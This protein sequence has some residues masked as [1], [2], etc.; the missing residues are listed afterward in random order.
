MYRPSQTP[1]LTLS[2]ERIAADVD[3]SRREATRAGMAWHQ[4]TRTRVRLSA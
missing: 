2:S 4:K 3:P 1:R